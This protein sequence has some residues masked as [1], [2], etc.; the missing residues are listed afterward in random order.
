MPNQGK[1]QFLTDAHEF[2]LLYR[3]FGKTVRATPA[4]APFRT[5]GDTPYRPPTEKGF[6]E[7][8]LTRTCAYLGAI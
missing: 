5:K 8:T 1:L 4:I 7:S 6:G 3:E 2:R